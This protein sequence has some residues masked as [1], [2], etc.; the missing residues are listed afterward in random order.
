LRGQR[1]ASERRFGALTDE[2]R[3][4]REESDKRFEVM[5]R[6]FEELR[7]D[8]DAR[9]AE[10]RA[11]MDARLEELRADMDARFAE[12]RADMNARFA[13]ARADMNARFEAIDKRFDIVEGRLSL[14]TLNIGRFVDHAGHRLEDVV[15]GAMRFALHRP[16][17]RPD[18]VRLRQEFTDS[19]GKLGEKGR[20]IEIDVVAADGMT[21]FLE[22]K[23]SAKPRDVRALA[24]DAEFAAKM[25]GLAPGKYAAVLATVDQS[26]TVAEAC[27]A[28]RVILI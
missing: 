20:K 6:R 18:N 3:A 25:M 4:Q 11:D 10:A 23:A 7:A 9:F 22:A 19:E 21:Y 28:H 24:E 5:D 2:L 16:D 1:E 26:E 27:R 8:M 13:E 17:I 14:A 12:A 15:A